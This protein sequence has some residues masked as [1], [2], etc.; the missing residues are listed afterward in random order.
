MR[1]PMPIQRTVLIA[2]LCLSLGVT[3]PT[4]AQNATPWSPAAGSATA[5]AVG[6]AATTTPSMGSAVPPAAEAEKEGWL[7]TTPFANVSWPEIKMP[8]IAWKKPAQEGQPGFFAGQV[9]KVKTASRGFAQRTKLAWNKT[10]DKLKITGRGRAGQN[11]SGDE[12]P[13]FFARMFGPQESQTGPQTV[14]EFLAQDRPST[15]RR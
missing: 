6:P 7:M 5:P 14:P 15:K 11:G 1:N 2:T 10:V 8:K 9:D 3:A 13:G 4:A 12:E